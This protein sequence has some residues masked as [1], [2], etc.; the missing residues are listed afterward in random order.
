MRCRGH[1]PNLCSTPH[2]SHPPGHITQDPLPSLLRRYEQTSKDG[3]SEII[4]RFALQTPAAKK[5]VKVVFKATALQVTVA[6]EELI[7]GSLAGT[8]ALDECTWC[9]VE[10]GSELQVM[11]ALA[12]D[13]KWPTLLK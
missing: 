2:L 13:V 3:E 10:K 1:C 6:G 4:V 8:L 9:L 12:Q 5:D 11:L 7:N